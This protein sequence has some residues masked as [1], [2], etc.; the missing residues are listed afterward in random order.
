MKIIIKIFIVLALLLPSPSFA[1]GSK[2][3][4]NYNQSEQ[5]I[6]DED[7]WKP[8]EGYVPNE[9]TAIKIALAVWIPI[10]GKEHI[11]GK[12]P[13]KAVLKD[14]IWHVT[15]S[16]P[17]GWKGGVPEAEISKEDGRILKIE[18]GM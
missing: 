12:A 9:D 3:V 11:E 10:Y 4:Q 6:Q 2:D 17:L 8:E 18:H 13:Y 7:Q 14:G 5:Y 1:D 15:G 16:I